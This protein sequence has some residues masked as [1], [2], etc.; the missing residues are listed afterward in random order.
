[1]IKHDQITEAGGV[2]RKYKYTYRIGDF[3][4]RLYTTKYV[5]I[6]N[7]GDI[8]FR[9]IIETPDDLKAIMRMCQINNDNK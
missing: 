6:S 4:L 7:Y 1:M 2:Q 5:S 9:G 8:V 3:V